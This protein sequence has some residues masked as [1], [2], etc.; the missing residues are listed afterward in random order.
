MR[1]H[2]IGDRA[3]VYKRGY[4]M[5]I[6]LLRGDWCQR[7][8]LALLY[9]TQVDRP[10]LTSEYISLSPYEYFA[11]KWPIMGKG[12]AAFEVELNGS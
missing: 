6:T 8:V 5:S 11:S 12:G 10:N 3:R 9:L 4:R 7:A 2:T 1:S